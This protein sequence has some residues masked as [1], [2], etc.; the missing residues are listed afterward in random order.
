MNDLQMEKKAIRASVL[1]ARDAL[2]A[3][4]RAI[5]STRVCEAIIASTPY[6]NATTLLAYM[7]FGTELSTE[8]II[9]HALARGK[10][11]VLPRVDKAA[12]QLQLHRIR[13]LD[14]LDSGIWGIR[15]PRM[16]AEI[17]MPNEIDFILVPG[18][19]FDSAGFRIGYGKGFYDKL[20]STVNPASTRLSAAFDCQ[21]IDAVPNEAH[22][23][24]V[25]IIITPT[26][27]ILISH[28]R[29]NH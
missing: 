12:Q 22:D 26:Q 15:E 27:K 1:A 16:D 14:E 18:V 9:D 25:D 4:A 11:L 21:I 10:T 24:R 23:Q 20:L 19:A 3:D 13:H 6:K 7:S 8:N 28:D 5:A 17:V 29:K 2:A